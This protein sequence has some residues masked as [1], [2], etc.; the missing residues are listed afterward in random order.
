MKPNSPYVAEL[1]L[2]L[3]DQLLRHLKE[4]GYEIL[5][6]PHTLFQGKK[7]GVICTLYLSGKLVIQGKDAQAL[8]EFF[9]EPEL[10][11]T[12]THGYES[13]SIDKTARIGVDEA[14]KGD[15]FGPLCIAG[16]YA[17]GKEIEELLAIGV[18]D[19]KKMKDSSIAKMARLIRE[20]VPYHIVRIGPAKYNELYLKFHNLNL[21][22][23]W[24]HATVIAA[25]SEKTGCHRA[26]IDQFS[27]LPLV[28]RA[29]EQK[30]LKIDFSKKTK[31]ESDP[32]VA[33]ASILARDA[34]VSGMDILSK[35]L[36]VEL[37]KGA[38]SQVVQ[39]G[40]KLLKEKGKE[41]FGQIAKKHFKT[42]DEIVGKSG[43]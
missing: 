17:G 18:K 27:H 35:W 3:S 10:L 42:L 24:G 39:M 30:A 31:G 4:Q 2:A 32:V 12:F 22:L 14:G 6:P 25:L 21:L 23:A 7:K 33:A 38:S 9:I 43:E 13:L 16:V 1:S 40:R 36:G 19:S 26:H 41:I 8:I 5:K 15:F 37:P 28:E 11:K 20:K 34:F 29:L